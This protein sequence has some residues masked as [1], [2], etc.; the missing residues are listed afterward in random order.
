MR[1]ACLP[2][3]LARDPDLQGGRFTECAGVQPWELPP[4]EGQEQTR[5]AAAG[6]SEAG[7]LPSP[8]PCAHGSLQRLFKRIGRLLGRP[9]GGHWRVGPGRSSG[10]AAESG[11]RE[12]EGLRGRYLTHPFEQRPVP[13]RMAQS[14]CFDEGLTV[15]PG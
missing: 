7:P 8:T 1:Y 9:R 4:D 3:E 2:A 15:D 11:L 10:L 5:I 13:E 14:E 12:G 6:Q